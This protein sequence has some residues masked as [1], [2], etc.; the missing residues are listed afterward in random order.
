MPLSRQ[1]HPALRDHIRSYYGFSEQTPGPLR[2]REGPGSSVVVVLSFE[3]DWMLGEALAPERPFKRFTSFVAGMHDAAVLTEH[4]GRAEGMQV[5]IAPPAAAM[6]LGVPMHEL[7]CRTV[8]FEALFGSD[9]LVE[10]VAG[11][12][13]WDA[14]FELIEAEFAKRLVEAAPRSPGV[15]WAWRRLAQ[16]HGRI[17]VE[18]L[19]QELG[20]S[21]KR[22]VARFR[23]D[24]GLAPKTV[25]RLLR[26][27]HAIE[28]ASEG[29]AW[30]EVAYASGYY[31]QAH[32]VNEF[33]AITGAT[34]NE[35]VAAA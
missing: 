28:L 18:T 17:R 14:R 31:D 5:N 1:P 3:H 9:E 19:C 30:A 15:A 11:A 20:W 26:L 22:L 16:T 24:V 6:L 27:E 32:L 4:R 33:R 29:Q 23:E 25:A 7:A 8:P 10:R 2:R 35:Y 12:P 34:P 21:R 13:S